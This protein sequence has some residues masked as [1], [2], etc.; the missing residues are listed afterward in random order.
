MCLRSRSGGD[1]FT[2]DTI[3][4]G[5]HWL[6]SAGKS[7]TLS[8]RPKSTGWCLTRVREELVQ[9]DVVWEFKRRANNCNVTELPLNQIWNHEPN[10][11]TLVPHRTDRPIADLSTSSIIAEH[12]HRQWPRGL[13]N[14]DVLIM[15]MASPA[16]LCNNICTRFCVS[17]LS[18]TRHQMQLHQRRRPSVNF[19]TQH[20]ASLRFAPLVCSAAPREEK[21][22]VEEVVV[23]GDDGMRR[24]LQILL[25]GAEGIYI[26]W[27][28]LL[29][30]A[31]VGVFWFYCSFLVTKP[32]LLLL[33]RSLI[34]LWMGWIRVHRP[35]QCCACLILNVWDDY[36]LR[37][38]FVWFTCDIEE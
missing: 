36:M 18:Q 13:Q 16:L 15:T 25:W 14:D 9:N 21:D 31:P 7:W 34:I 24:L 3:G 4:F 6:K 2:F 37:N 35:H 11:A 12:Q 23:E 8:L 28:F 5:S 38:D 27:L 19:H 29:P 26:F 33:V 10:L 32:M 30:Y 17:S 20:K 1:G 22:V